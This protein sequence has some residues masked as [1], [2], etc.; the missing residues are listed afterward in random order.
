MGEAAVSPDAPTVRPAATGDRERWT[1]MWRKF[2]HDK[3]GEP[4]DRETEAVNWGRILDPDHPLECILSLD[5]GGEAQGFT[6]YQ[7]LAFTWSRR[8]ICY[9]MDIFVRPEARRM[10]HATA[11]MQAL[12]EIGRREEWDKIFW[13]TEGGNRRAQRFYDRLATRMDYLRYDLDLSD[14]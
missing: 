4:G 12:V 7:P 11:M 2:L 13:M 14:R 6:L 8:D 9:L 5:A 10:G 3:P 1:S